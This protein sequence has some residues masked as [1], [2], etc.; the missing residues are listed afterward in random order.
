MT[1]SYDLAG[2]HV[3]HVTPATSTP[4]GNSNHRPPLLLVHG[5][6]HGAWCWEFWLERLPSLGWEAH[7][8]SLRNHPGSYGIDEET[9]RSKTRLDDY[10]RDVGKVAG[11][12]GVPAVVIGHSMG[13]ITTQRFAALHTAA[14]HTAAPH[15]VGGKPPAALVL[16]ASAPP[17]ELNHFIPEPFPADKPFFLARDQFAQR[18]FHN[19]PKE[20]L[21]R[22]LDRLVPESTA[23]INEILTAPGV[24]VRPEEITCPILVVT[25]GQDH[26]SVPKD[27]S[28]ADYYGADYMDDP[29]NGHDL[30][31]ENG[32]EAL[33][34]RIMD[35]VDS[36][37]KAD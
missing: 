11:H 7:A 36:R 26:S 22:A 29:E 15:T 24:S 4:N 12:I 21:D 8:L 10:A 33:L 14:L 16:L 19:I 31:L 32:W 2:L 20:R 17:G 5:A 18:F 13:G 6:A 25:A 30:M 27:R 28:L 1:Q 34:V 23:V 3:D 9:F 37:V 35:W